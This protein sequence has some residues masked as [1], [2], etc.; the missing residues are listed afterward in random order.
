MM[1]QYDFSSTDTFSSAASTDIQPSEQ[2]LQ[3]IL[4]FACSFQAI[5]VDGITFEVYLN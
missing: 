3:R 2:T 5:E 1:Q 4:S